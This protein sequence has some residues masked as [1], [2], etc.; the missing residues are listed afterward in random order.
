MSVREKGA[1][2]TVTACAP[3]RWSRADRVSV[4]PVER[5]VRAP[6]VGL[7]PSPRRRGV[8]RVTGFPLNCLSGIGVCLGKS[9]GPPDREDA[10]LGVLHRGHRPGSHHDDWGPR[11]HRGAGEDTFLSAIRCASTPLHLRWTKGTRPRP[12]P[13]PKIGRRDFFDDVRS[14]PPAS[15]HRGRMNVNSDTVN[16]GARFYRDVPGDPSSGPPHEPSLNKPPNPHFFRH[17]RTA[18]RSSARSARRS[19]PVASW[20]TASTS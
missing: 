12:S 4:D 2:R 15:A 7:F 11:L 3:V 6:L 10:A 19:T 9:R 14:R 13:S 17:R 1:S 16:H 8:A 20:C 18:R 5:V